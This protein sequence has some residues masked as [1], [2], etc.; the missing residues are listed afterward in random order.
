M[1]GGSVAKFT[2]KVE[3]VNKDGIF[4]AFVFIPIFIGILICFIG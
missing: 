2:K 4:N 3:P 1:T